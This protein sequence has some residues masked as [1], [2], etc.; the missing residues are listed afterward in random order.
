MSIETLNIGIGEIHAGESFTVI[1]RAC[2]GASVTSG[3]WND[4]IR[5]EKVDPTLFD[6]HLVPAKLC[7]VHSE[8]SEAMEGHRKGLKDD[9]LPHR[10]MLEV[11]LAD[12]VIRIA[13]LAGALGLDVGGAIDEKLAYNRQRA[14]HKLENRAKVG[15][16]VY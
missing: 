7:L 2:H 16:K 14:D 10:P 13:D 1:T 15:G 12:A 6:K 5:D 3:W 11:E 9:H 4:F 8:I